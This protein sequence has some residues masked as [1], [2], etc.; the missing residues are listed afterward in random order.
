MLLISALARVLARDTRNQTEPSTPLSFI[1]PGTC[2][3]LLDYVRRREELTSV[4]DAVFAMYEKGQ[5]TLWVSHAYAL[6]DAGKAHAEL[7]S[8]R[9]TGKLLLSIGT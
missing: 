6:E 9:S 7:E 3:L 8:R 4:T 2:L 1:H 5:L